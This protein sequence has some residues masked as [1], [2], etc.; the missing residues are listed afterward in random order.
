MIPNNQMFF[1]KRGQ[2]SVL[3][4]WYD[5]LSVKPSAGL[6]TDLKIMADGMNEDGDWEEA[7][8]ISV[9]AALETDEQ[10]LRPFKTTS[11]DDFIP[12]NSPTLS[13]EGYN[14]SDGSDRLIDC[15]WN[16]VDNGVKFT[17]N[18]AYIGIYGVSK[19][20]TGSGNEIFGAS[21]ENGDFGN[22]I[23]STSLT[24]TAITN[25][26]QTMINGY[27]NTTSTPSKTGLSNTIKRYYVGIK[28]TS[29][30]SITKYINGVQNVV[31]SLSTGLTPYDFS[32]LGVNYG[33]VYS[34]ATLHTSRACIVGS[35]LIDHD[36]VAARLNTFFASRGLSI[37]NY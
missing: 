37:D 11:G 33:G 15:K 30:S 6:W 27:F 3:Q 10:R 8:L 16:P 19:T 34:T 24:T 28:R 22:C 5:S 2:V 32:I 21:N 12:T 7:D 17:E 26:S 29:S 23:I 1:P 4:P 14:S 31:G 13:V 35:S 20:S 18:N 25:A 36:R 9:H